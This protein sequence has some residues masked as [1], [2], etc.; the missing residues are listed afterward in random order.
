MFNK[1]EYQRITSISCLPNGVFFASPVLKFHI[2]IFTI[3]QSF[4]P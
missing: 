3:V 2:N 1:S 4:G